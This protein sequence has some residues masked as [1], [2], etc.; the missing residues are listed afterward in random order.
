LHNVYYGK[1]NEYRIMYIK[2]WIIR[3]FSEQKQQKLHRELKARACETAAF[4][5]P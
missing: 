1:F 3:L 4:P 5:H 2:E